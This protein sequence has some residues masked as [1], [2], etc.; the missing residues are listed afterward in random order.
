MKIK[1]LK[2]QK[3]KCTCKKKI[4]EQ[5]YINSSALYDANVHKH[6]MCDKEYYE[7]TCNGCND[8]NNYNNYNNY[9]AHN[10]QTDAC[11]KYKIEKSKEYSKNNDKCKPK[12]KKQC[13]KKGPM[14]PTGPNGAIG[15]KGTIGPIRTNRTERS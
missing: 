9:N 12:C 14:G 6:H 1:C 2:C 7:C 15:P 3:I 8:F 10:D 11:N 4:Y 5:K 13:Y